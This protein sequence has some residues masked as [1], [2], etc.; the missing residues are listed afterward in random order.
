MAR[1]S[2][3]DLAPRTRRIIVVGGTVDVV[4]RAVALADL[5]GR[6]SAEVRG[7]KP[8]WATALALVS[9]G[10]VLPVAYLLRGRRPT[11]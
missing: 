1:K 9:S 6:P 3:S 5:K 2:W 8:A 7:P 10:G 11:H 4:L